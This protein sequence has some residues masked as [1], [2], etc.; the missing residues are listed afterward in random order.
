MVDDTVVTCTDCPTDSD[1]PLP[2]LTA[3]RVRAM[4][5]LMAD[6]VVRVWHA[7][8]KLSKHSLAFTGMKPASSVPSTRTRPSLS[9]VLVLLVLTTLSHQKVVTTWHTASVMLP[10]D[11]PKLTLMASEP[12][13]RATLENTP[14]LTALKHVPDV[15]IALSEHLQTPWRDHL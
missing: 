5:D 10:M 12:V 13:H 7:T 8:P 3:A 15:L 2:L 4:Q 1:S 9:L 6:W 14:P 11:T